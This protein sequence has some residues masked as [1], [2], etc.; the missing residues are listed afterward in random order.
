MVSDRGIPVKAM[1]GGLPGMLQTVGRAERFAALQA[2]QASS[3]IDTIVTDLLGLV[4]EAERWDPR[5]AMAE[6]KHATI[7]RAM[8]N[9]VERQGGARPTFRWTPAHLKYP[10]AMS[11]NIRYDDWVGNGWADAFAKWGAQSIQVKEE[12]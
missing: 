6:G 10:E 3:N 1:F 2:I 12:S 4:R 11:R 7:W 8:R 9:A 5:L